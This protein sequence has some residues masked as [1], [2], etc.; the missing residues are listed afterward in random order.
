ML[1][2]TCEIKLFQNYF[3]FRRRLP[4]FYFSIWNL[5]E[6]VSKLVQT[7]IS[8]CEYFPTCSLSPT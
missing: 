4:E 7:I 2:V 5:T 8:A 6:I 3:S 1:C